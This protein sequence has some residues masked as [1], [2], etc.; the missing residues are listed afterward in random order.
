MLGGM[1]HRATETSSPNP[2]N[3]LGILYA[4]D[5]DEPH[6]AQQEAERTTSEPER[7]PLTQADIDAACVAAVE[8]ARLE[9]TSEQE[10]NRTTTLATIGTT[11]A[12]IR[13]T[14]EHTTLACAEGTVTTIL[15]LLTGVLPE[16]CRQHG[17]TEVRAL[18]GRLLPVIQSQT[19]IAVRVHP[20]VVSLVQRDVGELDPDLASMIVVTAGPFDRADVRVAWEHGSMTRD[21]QQIMQAIQ[22]ALGQL[23]LHQK[24]EAPM[25]RTMAYAE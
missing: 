8:Q 5:F 9:W 4:E 7:P 15:S 2:T 13:D 14:C 11:L 20:D 23:G 6:H 25:K 24:I 19:K 16:F 18:L 22:D 12:N 21:T 10:R 1:K 17:P 3:F